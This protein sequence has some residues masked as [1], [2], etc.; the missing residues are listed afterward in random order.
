MSFAQ[1]GIAGSAEREKQQNK[2]QL[3]SKHIYQCAHPKVEL[4]PSTASLNCA[5][6][7]VIKDRWISE[8]LFLL[9]LMT[10]TE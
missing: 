8:M 10:L 3:E 1:M 7:G 2:A 5:W 9:F 4:E 6:H